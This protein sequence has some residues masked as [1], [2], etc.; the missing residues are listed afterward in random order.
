LE[1]AARTPVPEF[2]F[3]EDRR[4]ITDEFFPRVVREGRG[5]A[6]IRFRHFKTGKPV[7]MIYNVFYIQD[8]AGQPVGLATVSR[9]ITERKQAEAKLRESEERFRRV[10]EEGPLGVA[11]EARN[12]RFLKVNSALCQMVG[13]PEEELLQK[14]SVDI[15]HP[16]DVGGDIELSERLFRGE[17]PFYRLQKRYVKKTGEIMWVNLTVSLLRDREGDSLQRLTM[18]ED[19]TE[20][21]RNQEEAILR[22][23]L[24]SLGTLAGGIAHDFNNLLGGVLAQAE[25]ALE[26][27]AAGSGPEEELKAI[28]NVAIRGSEIVRELMIYA[29]RDSEIRGLVDVSRIAKEMLELLKVSVSKHARL[30]TDLGQDLPAVRTNAAQVRQV[31]MNLVTN[32]SEALGERDGV[33]RLTTRCVRVGPDSSAVMSDSLA[34]GDYL[35][36]E[37]SDNGCG[38][39]AETRARVFDPFFTTKSAGR[40]LGLAVVAGIVRGLS[41]EIRA[42]SEPGKGT[43]FQILLPCEE[44]TAQATHRMISH[45]NEKLQPRE[46]TILVVEDEATIRRPIAKMLRKEGF[47]VIEANDGSTALDLIHKDN[48]DVLLLDISLPGATSREVFE[49]ARYVRPDVAVIVTSAHSEETAAAAVGNGMYRFVRKPCSIDDLIQAIRESLSS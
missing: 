23:K 42:A 27:L 33:I 32:A 44:P 10:F 39:S 43:T 7:W 13:Y 3:P 48:I 17:I 45:V 29:G 22:Q 2:F 5:E 24:E 36:L 30:E 16:D 20:A 46:A 4:F 21:K 11:L 47:S 35:Q 34:D 31:V 14:T 9:D 49:A 28:R 1:E 26:E 25:L 6:E 38:M 37:V 19:V 8:P 41:G 15:T 12:Y 18:I 40:G